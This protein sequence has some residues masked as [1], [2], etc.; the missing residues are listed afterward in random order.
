MNL[1]AADDAGVRA[2]AAADIGLRTA[3]ASLVAVSGTVG[4]LTRRAWTG[5]REALAFYARLGVDADAETVFPAPPAGTEVHARRLGRLP[6]APGVGRAEMLCFT[7][8]HQVGYEP[9]APAYAAQTRNATAWV[10]HWRHDE[11]DG[12][13][14]TIIVVH[15][16]A[17]SPAWFNSTFFSLPWFYG[18]GCDVALVTLPFHGKRS[19]RWAPYSGHGFFAN[20][21]AHMIEAIRQSV[22]DVRVLVSHLLGAGAPRVGITGLSLGGLMTSLLASTEPRL[23]LAIPNAAVT[24]VGSLMDEWWP[25]NRLV[26]LVTRRSGISPDD[27]RAALVPVSP[28][29][30]RPVLA[31]DRLFVIGGLGDRLAPPDQSARLWEHWGRPMVH[32]YPG[33]HVLH[34]GRGAYLRRIGHF[35]RQT[36]FSAG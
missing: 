3:A 13:R 27:L 28:L 6:L 18:H 24:D 21:Q 1:L 31:K 32:W 30:Y 4:L 20:G 14:P 9:L 19:A 35:L 2:V 22:C 7:S 12:L 10:Q 33:S 29:R 17:A 26:H 8:P 36:G 5:E 25:A 16:F 34:F 11:D 23:H 15:G